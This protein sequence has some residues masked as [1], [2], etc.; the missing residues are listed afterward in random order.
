MKGSSFQRELLDARAERP[1]TQDEGICRS[2][3]VLLVLVDN[4]RLHGY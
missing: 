3:L 1:A 4:L 2:H